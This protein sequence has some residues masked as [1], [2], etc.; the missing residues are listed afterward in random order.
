MGI[1]K[2]RGGAIEGRG[3]EEE[4][5]EDDFT[6]F[7]SFNFKLNNDFTYLPYEARYREATWIFQF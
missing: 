5:D 2:R 3:K 1:G 7:P 6:Y 4:E